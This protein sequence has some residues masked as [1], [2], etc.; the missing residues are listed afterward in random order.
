MMRTKIRIYALIMALI[1]VTGIFVACK[2]DPPIPDPLDEEIDPSRTQLYVYNFNGGYGTEWLVQAK[3][4]YEALHA[5]DTHWEEGK[6]GV[7]I[8]INPPKSHVNPSA[9]LTNRDEVYFTEYAYYYTYLAEGILG[10]ITQAVTGDNT[11]YGDKPG[12]TIESKLTAEQKAYYGIEENGE[13]KYYA[14]PHYAGYAGLVYNVDLFESKGYYFAKEPGATG[15]I[16]D[17][18]IYNADD[19]RSSGPDG[20]EDTYDDG[21]PSTYEEFFTLCRYIAMDGNTPVCWP[22]ANYKDYLNRLVE[23]LVANNE[24]LDQ[25][26]LKYSL[27]GVASSLGT[28]VDDQFV[29]DEA[30]TAITKGLGAETYRSEGIYRALEFL[31]KLCVTEDFHNSLA[32]NNGYS[33]MNAQEDFL[34]AG[35]DGET[36]PIAMMCEGIWWEMEAI[37]T[38]TDMTNSMGEEFSRNNRNFGFMPLPKTSKEQIGQKNTLLDHIY[39]L[40][41]MKS[42]VAEWK[43]PLA[44]DFIKFVNSD[45]SLVEFSQVTSTPKALNYTMTQ[46][47]MKAMSP[48]GRS[49]M[50]VKN[51]S[52]ILYPFSPNATYRNAQSNFTYDSMYTSQITGLGTFKYAAEAF[53]DHNVSPEDYFKGMYVYYSSQPY[54]N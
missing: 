12:Q 42:N 43:I 53:H 13:T 51:N 36:A 5:E 28:I 1:L 3:K 32:F 8:Y 20:I 23:S 19:P 2:E 15:D 29:A 4:R 6:K 54:L 7:Q 37:Q 48:F 24:G 33:H 41:F 16:S 35:H 50:T 21:L 40:C 46:E 26:L 44:L 30:V 25:M 17:Y 52:N 10:D 11:A 14:L 22:G 34:Y 39:S 49:L 47:Q 38:F 18:F 31:N 45:A 9:V 27:E